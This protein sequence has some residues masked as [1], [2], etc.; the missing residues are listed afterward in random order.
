MKKTEKNHKKQQ[1]QNALQW[2]VN[3]QRKVGNKGNKNRKK[4]QNQQ[5]ENVFSGACE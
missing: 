5:E 1:D 2:F 3:K 4:S